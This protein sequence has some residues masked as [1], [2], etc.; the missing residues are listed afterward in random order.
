MLV[1]EEIKYLIKPT[2]WSPRDAGVK[3]YEELLE[4]VGCS[5]K[6]VNC[7]VGTGYG[8]V[9]LSFIDKA[10]TEIHCHARGAAY[11]IGKGGLVVDIG[12]QDS[13]A[14]LINQKGKVLDFT[15]NDKCAA[16][17]GR[18]LQVIA[19][20][21]GVDVSELA[22][23][24]VGRNPLEINS[25]CTV[26][27]ESEVISLLAK[28]EDK[29]DI[30]AG[31]HRSVARRV[32]SMASRFGPVEQVIFTG[33]VAQNK[34]MQDKLTQASGCPV[35][36]PEFSQVAGALGAALYARDIIS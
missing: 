32:W 24:A 18:F 10:V 22:D 28:G 8:R 16:G 2:G 30:I 4:Q 34:D 23:L 11:L 19:T 31:I 17:T 36:V 21:L 9:S 5:P 14:I 7:R 3:A 20:A 15:M 33:G 27:A 1:G 6:D 29:R 35:I 26:F 25:M 13:K 12:G